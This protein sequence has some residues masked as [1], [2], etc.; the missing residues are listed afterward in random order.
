VP[1]GGYDPFAPDAQIHVINV[2]LR[3]AP[4]DLG[5]RYLL[6]IPTAFSIAPAEVSSLI[7]AGRSILMAS[8]AFKALVKS[9]GEAAVVP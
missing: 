4:D 6:Q 3:D 5:R 7:D 1:E 8:P 2:N 9:M